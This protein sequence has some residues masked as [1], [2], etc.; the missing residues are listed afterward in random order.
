MAM[1]DIEYRHSAEPSED[2]DIRRTSIEDMNKYLRGLVYEMQM[3]DISSKFISTEGEGP[4]SLII[5][6]KKVEDI[7]AGLDI[8]PLDTEDA[9]DHGKVSMVTFGRP[10]LDWNKEFVEDIPD[11]L[12]KNA[13]S[14][15]YA[16]VVKNR[17][18]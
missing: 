10:T 5:N 2:A 1:I 13:I 14:K 17:I 9:C 12:V 15:A 4:N 6:G 18:L 7:L 3:A 11:V 16:D 8:K